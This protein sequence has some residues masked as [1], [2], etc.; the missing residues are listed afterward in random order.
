MRSRSE[1]VLPTWAPR[2][3]QLE[4]RRLYETDAKGIYDDELIDKV[5]YGLLARCQSFVDAVEAVGGKARCPQCSSVVA[6]TG[7]KDEMLRCECGWQLPWS[8]YFK[9]IQHKQLSGA[10]PVLEQFRS[11]VLAFPG[12]RTSQQ[13]TML[14]DRLIHG[15]H[16]YH[17]TN[18]PS[19]PVAV[20]L[21]EGRIREVVAFLDDLSLGEKSTAGV[22]ENYAQWDRGIRSNPGWYPSRRGRKA[23]HEGRGDRLRGD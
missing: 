2:V 21:I 17:K 20:N 22:A 1:T 19:R 11:F 14:T 13:K 3:T 6:H 10:E 15:F 5:G 23:G 8:D 16:W 18:G 12:A 7:R 9:T 4:I